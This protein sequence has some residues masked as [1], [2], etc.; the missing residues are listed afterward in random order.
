MKI[1]SLNLEGY[2]ALAPMAG[3]ADRAMREICDS[4]GAAYS[5]GELTSAKAITLGDKKSPLLL[6]KGLVRCFGSQLFGSEPDVMAFAAKV[7]EEKNPDFI[8]INM[9]C[10]A[11]KVAN[12]GGGR[13]L[14]R[15]PKLVGE[16][17][18]KVVDAV[19]IPITV[20]SIPFIP[21]KFLLIAT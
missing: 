12:N 10:P 9:G 19:N 15:E 5:V 20:K 4:F 18:K 3:V 6:E 14:L 16:I 13:S 17:V 1:G 21:S 11:P 7:A 8:D 2:A